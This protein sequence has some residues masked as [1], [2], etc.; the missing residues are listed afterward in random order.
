MAEHFKWS[1]DYVFNIKEIDDQH[2]YFV[3]LL[4]RVYDYFL[5]SAP[6]ST[7]E[8]ILDELVNY[9]LIHFETEEKYFAEFNYEGAEDHKEAHRELKAKIMAFQDESKTGTADLSD[10]LIDFLEDWLI[11]HLAKMDRKYV[12]CFHNHGLK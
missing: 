7:Q 6:R 9:A 4:D 3:S 8:I 1:D 12:E 11:D 10:D 2:R 5:E